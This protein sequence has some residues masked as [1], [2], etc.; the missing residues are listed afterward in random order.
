MKRRITNKELDELKNIENLLGELKKEKQP[1]QCKQEIHIPEVKVEKKHWI[2]EIVMTKH[3]NQRA[4]ERFQFNKEKA[5]EYFREQLKKATRIGKVVD[6][7]GN[8]GYLYGI[9]QI[10]IIVSIDL[11]EIKTVYRKGSVSVYEPIRNTLCELH[12]KELRKLERKEQTCL[13]R[14]TVYKYESAIEKSELEYRIYKTK[15]PSIKMVCKARIKALDE[16][17]V[18]LENEIDQIKKN[19]NLV[20]KSLVSVI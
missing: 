3:A 19:R 18:E 10:A 12:K 5:I 2:D 17:L 1:E 9:D 11:K 6:E 15:S 8:E 7:G 20:A 4:S 13:K 16:R 14:L